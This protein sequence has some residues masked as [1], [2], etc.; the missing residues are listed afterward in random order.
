MKKIM[1]ILI[2]IVIVYGLIS[3][4]DAEKLLI[5]NEAIRMRIIPNSN[6]SYDQ[7]MKLKVRNKLQSTM[8]QMLKNTKSIE[9]ARTVIESNLDHL[10][11]E[12]ANVL[13]EN[14]YDLGY[15][16][17]FGYHYFPAKEYKGVTYDEG[18]YE[19]ILVTLGKGEG[20][21]WWCVLFPPLCLLE[22][23]ES[24]EV[25]YKFFLKEILDKYF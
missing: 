6:S 25:E 24:D 10:D 4:V 3:D 13:T 18:L 12:V 5:P 9:E 16:L 1:I 15:K 7:E 2:A 17:Q 14:E 11:K 20:D 23:E 21:N 8:Y 19:S 22:A